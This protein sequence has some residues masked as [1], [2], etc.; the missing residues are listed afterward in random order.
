MCVMANSHVYVIGGLEGTNQKRLLTMEHLDARKLL[1][2]GQH[3]EEIGWQIIKVD[4]SGDG[5]KL[6]YCLFA[7][8]TT[9]TLVVL[10][11]ERYS[12]PGSFGHLLQINA[13]DQ[14]RAVV[15]DSFQIGLLLVAPANQVF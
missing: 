3:K 6:H 11:G 9:D 15:T 4:G 10:G 7:P 12:E 2:C 5:L 1:D 14:D 8:L 13:E